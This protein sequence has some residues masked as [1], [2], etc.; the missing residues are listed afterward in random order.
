[1]DALVW[2]QDPVYRSKYLVKDTDGVEKANPL[3]LCNLLGNLYDMEVR[4]KAQGTEDPNFYLRH[5]LS[6]LGKE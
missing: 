3:V 2:R 6:W 5:Q 4:A 1:M